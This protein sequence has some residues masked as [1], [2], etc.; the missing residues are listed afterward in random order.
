MAVSKINE[1]KPVAKKTAAAE[2]AVVKTVVA[3]TAPAKKTAT[4]KASA[5][6]TVA[7]KTST[8]KTANTKISPEQHYKMIEMAAYF[9]AERNGFSGSP[10]DYWTEA[11]TQIKGMLGK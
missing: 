8:K 9:I 5:V 2:K 1:K 3:K 7:K 6:K 10:S 4:P 11:E